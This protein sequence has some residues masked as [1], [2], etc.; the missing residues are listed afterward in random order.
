M[1]KRAQTFRHDLESQARLNDGNDHYGTI[2]SENI[3]PQKPAISQSHS[4][5]LIIGIM[6]T[7]SIA[8]S[9]VFIVIVIAVVIIIIMTL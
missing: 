9:L 8:I 7:L 1:I 6:I 2:W 4:I 3:C 5:I